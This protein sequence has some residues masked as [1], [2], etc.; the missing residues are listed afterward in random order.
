MS[1]KQSR[2][3]ADMPTVV[4]SQI[5]QYIDKTF[6]DDEISGS[7]A[8]ILSPA[9]SAALSALLALV[10]QVPNI[11]LPSEPEA[12]ARMIQS[13]EEIRRSARKAESQDPQSYFAHGPINLLPSA[14]EEPSAV[15][16]IRTA[17]ASCP[18]EI[19]PLGS[20]E[21]TF[22]KEPD[23]R[24][25][26]LR[27]LA[28]TRS[29]LLNEEWKPATV[30]AGSLLE[31]LLLWAIEQKPEA[32]IQ[33]A[34]SSAL[35]KAKLKKAPP[36]DPLR[37]DLHEYI[38]VAAEL[39]LI[40]ADSAAQAR[41]AKDFRNL[42]HPGRALRVARDCDRGSALAANAAVEFVARDLRLRFPYV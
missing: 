19:T 8:I 29:A 39:G 25:S 16:V 38:E 12:Y 36:G 13:V 17:L 28:T 40:E 37:W 34:I 11:L 18:D 24:S 10:E 22:I 4:P 26:L 6:S 14:P 15:G 31:A 2:E 41:L 35:L 27:D 21:L 20:Q 23:I 42:I 30:I 33:A 32:D 7:K 1:E 9:R 3:G 5:V